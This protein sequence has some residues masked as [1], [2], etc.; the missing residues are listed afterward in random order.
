MLVSEL[1]MTVSTASI[2]VLHSIEVAHLYPQVMLPIYQGIATSHTPL[3]RRRG[4]VTLRGLY[5]VPLALENPL[6]FLGSSN[7]G[8]P[9]LTAIAAKSTQ[10]P[11]LAF[12]IS[13]PRASHTT[14][15]VALFSRVVVER[16]IGLT[17]SH[18]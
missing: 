10:G 8:T 12:L 11:P 14:I 3:P 18:N 2:P 9:R 6:Q 16:E 7:V 1:L 15:V 13:Q 17:F 5:K 4:R